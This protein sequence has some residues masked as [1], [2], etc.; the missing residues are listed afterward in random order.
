MTGAEILLKAL[1]DQGVDTVFGYPGGCVLPIYDELFKQEK[2]RHILVR[3]EGGAVHAAEGYAR[4]TGK[5]G[6]VFVTSGPGATNA[7]TGLMDAMLDSIPVVCISGQVGTGLIGTDAFQEADM[8]GITRPCTKHNYLIKDANV[9][10][11][12]LHQAFNIARTGRPGPVLLDLPKDVQMGE[13]EYVSPDK[14]T[15]TSYSYKM[16]GDLDQIEKAVDL[17]VNAKKPVFYTGGG[18]INSGKKASELLT[19]L[20][21]QTGFPITSTLMGLGA[22]P[23]SHEKWLGMPGMHGT[24]EANVAMYQCDVMICVGAR[25][26]DRVTG[27]TDE[28]SPYSKK[29]HIDIDPSSINKNVPVDIPIVGDVACVLRDMLKIWKTK[30]RSAQTKELASWNKQIKEWKDVNCLGFVQGEGPIKPQ[31]AIEALYNS[32]KDKDVFIATEVGQ[33]QMFTAQRYNF[34]K[35]N[36]F[37]TSGGLGTMGY[38]LPS[39]LGVQ[40][41]NPESLVVCVSGECSFMMNVQE[42]STAAQYKLPVKICMLNNQY[43]G[44]VKQWQDMLY[45]KRYSQI[46]LDGMP[47]L[48]KLADAFGW[49]YMAVHKPE[50]LEYGMTTMVESEGPFLLR[51]I[52]DPHENCFP[53]NPAGYTHNKML[54]S[55][56]DRIEDL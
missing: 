15:H 10:A 13:G 42:M 18:V 17:M 21:H 50:D 7:V 52:I 2:I 25:F 5:V 36:R 48:E 30:K 45:D 3:Q 49:G 40:V 20:V 1:V 9:L 39:A 35:P 34:E 12:R 6:V 23:A 38:G 44:M 33:H 27:K 47:D 24:Y 4:S 29:I 43:M 37:M 28:F 19:K 51:V 46:H 56:N 41:A 26:D 14:S 32:T 22:F 16:D 31:A 11:K 55:E 54:L 53:I 8:T